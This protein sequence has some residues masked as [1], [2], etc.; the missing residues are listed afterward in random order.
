MKTKTHTSQKSLNGADFQSRRSSIIQTT[1]C[2]LFPKVN[3]DSKVGVEEF[4]KHMEKNLLK[5]DGQNYKTAHNI[6]PKFLTVARELL[7]IP[8]N[9]FNTI[10]SVTKLRIYR[11]QLHDKVGVRKNERAIR[12]MLGVFDMYIQFVQWCNDPILTTYAIA[13]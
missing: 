8:E 13:A 9:M 11:I 10:R 12:Q 1:N 5:N 7:D 3:L 2:T 6:Y 4:S